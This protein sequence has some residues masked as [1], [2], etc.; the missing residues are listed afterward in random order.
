MNGFPNQSDYC[1]K[2]KL[3]HNLVLICVQQLDIVKFAL[4]LVKISFHPIFSV[5]GKHTNFFEASR[6]ASQPYF[7]FSIT[8][9]AATSPVLTGA[10]SA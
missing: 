5:V 4:P 8:S 1:L 6:A 7:T 10:T 3:H 9:F 2:G